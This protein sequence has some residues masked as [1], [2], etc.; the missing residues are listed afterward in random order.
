[1]PSRERVQVVTNHYP[2]IPALLAINGRMS[3]LHV[4]RGASLDFDEAENVFAP[5]FRPSNQID[6]AAMPCSAKISRHHH[7]TF[8]AQIKVG[9]FFAAAPCPQMSGKLFLRR[10]RNQPVETVQNGLRDAGTEH[11][12]SIHALRIQIS[13]MHHKL[14][15]G[16]SG[17]FIATWVL[18]LLAVREGWDV[19]LLC[20]EIQPIRPTGQTTNTLRSL[21]WFSQEPIMA[22]GTYPAFAICIAHRMLLASVSI[23]FPPAYQASFTWPS[24]RHE[25]EVWFMRGISVEAN[26]TSLRID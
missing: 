24:T 26:V 23:Q 1:M 10:F 7:V 21:R 9:V 12:W 18:L 13:D 25:S 22:L 15:C 4:T 6:L 8:L 17:A 16:Y 11:R 14:C 5:V 20:A 2:K 19:D 3:G